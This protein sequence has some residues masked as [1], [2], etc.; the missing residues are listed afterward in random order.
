MRT[1]LGAG[2]IGRSRSEVV[3]F[4]RQKGDDF[5]RASA[6][7]LAAELTLGEPELLDD[8]A[9]ALD[10]SA[11]IANDLALI[12]GKL[13]VSVVEE[14]NTSELAV[15]GRLRLCCFLCSRPQAQPV[16][17]GRRRRTC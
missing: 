11:M 16:R 13:A 10:L 15:S 17:L 6:K 1:T 4:I 2:L 12:A 14:A 7:C 3:A 9:L 8:G 5:C